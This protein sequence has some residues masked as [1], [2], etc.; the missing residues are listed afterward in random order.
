[1]IKAKNEKQVME[2]FITPAGQVIKNFLDDCGEGLLEKLIVADGSDFLR[3]QGA[4]QEL[5]EI[6]TLAN[7]A[8]NI[9]HS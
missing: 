8:R 4:V 1:M 2:A 7:N 3:T 6:T 9:L 5:K